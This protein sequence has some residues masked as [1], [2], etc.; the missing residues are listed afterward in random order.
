M[1][2][3]PQEKKDEFECQLLQCSAIAF[4][5]SQ[6]LV[7][8]KSMIGRSQSLSILSNSFLALNAMMDQLTMKP[9][10][11]VFLWTRRA[12][13]SGWRSW[14]VARGLYSERRLI[15]LHSILHLD[16]VYIINKGSHTLRRLFYNLFLSQP[17]HYL[18]KG[19][20]I[21]DYCEIV[22]FLVLFESITVIRRVCCIFMIVLHLI[23]ALI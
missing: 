9:L 17:C 7:P 3:H 18:I 6:S 13:K 16:P 22:A 1:V 14:K 4:S 2:S 19:V 10:L 12:M 5:P 11:K 21:A 15:F 20:D 8:A 23:V